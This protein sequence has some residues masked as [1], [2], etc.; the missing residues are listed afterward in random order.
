MGKLVEGKDFNYENGFV[1]LTESYLKNRKFC[2]GVKCKNCPFIPQY[3]K[4]STNTK[5]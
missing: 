2:C 1:V 3:Q 4:G 5:K